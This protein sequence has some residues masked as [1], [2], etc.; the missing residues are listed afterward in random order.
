VS[1]K[2]EKISELFINEI[3]REK[4]CEIEP[5]AQRFESVVMTQKLTHMQGV[6]LVGSHE[7]ELL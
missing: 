6:S 1:L 2:V 4:L 7:S 3:V 5:M